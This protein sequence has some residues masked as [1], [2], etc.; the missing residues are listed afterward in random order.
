MTK[1]ILETVLE[2][3]IVIP[4]LEAIRPLRFLG[5]SSM[6]SRGGVSSSSRDNRSKRDEQNNRYEKF[7]VQNFL[8]PEV[9][10]KVIL[11]FGHS[12]S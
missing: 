11:T 10:K 5:S 4:N 3:M 6:K 2:A 8:K 1:P 12:R 7:L 9:G